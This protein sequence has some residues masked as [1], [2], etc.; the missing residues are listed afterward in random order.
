[1]YSPQKRSLGVYHISEPGPALAANSFAC[2]SGCLR[3]TQKLGRGVQQIDGTPQ[4]RR[5][6]VNE[7]SA[8][9]SDPL[10]THIPTTLPPL[11]S[12]VSLSAPIRWANVRSF[13]FDRQL[14]RAQISTALS[15]ASQYLLIYLSVRRALVRGQPG[16][17]HATVSQELL[18]DETFRPF[19]SLRRSC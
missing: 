8:S 13:C 9:G 14:A 6:S 15:P 12:C 4:R 19:H 18:L 2:R 1:M 10:R 5:R 17:T 11:F 7:L 3:A 16:A